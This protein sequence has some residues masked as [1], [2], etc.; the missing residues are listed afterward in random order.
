MTHKSQ[1]YHRYNAL[2]SSHTEAQPF[3]QDIDCWHIFLM[4]IIIYLVISWKQLFVYMHNKNFF[5]TCMR[6]FSQS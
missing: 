4:K 2:N 1:H 5:K 6:Q 3:E